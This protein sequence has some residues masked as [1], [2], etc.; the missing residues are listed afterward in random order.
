MTASARGRRWAVPLAWMAVI[1]A[2]SSEAFSASS[3]LPLVEAF[4]RVMPA[5]AVVSPAGVNA[6]ART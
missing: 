3:T 2:L 1:L 4:L 6:R 5:E